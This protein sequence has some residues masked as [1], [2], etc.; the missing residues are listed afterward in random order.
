[1]LDVC[2]LSLSPS[3]SSLG[4]LTNGNIRLSSELG[5]N[6]VDLA[7]AALHLETVKGEPLGHARAK[8]D[9]S[10]AVADIVEPKGLGKGGRERESVCVCVCV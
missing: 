6:G 2:P 4:K 10:R 9:A 3:L 1:M 5:A 7:S 8:L